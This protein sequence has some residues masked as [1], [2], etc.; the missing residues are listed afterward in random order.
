MSSNHP[1]DRAATDRSP[2]VDRWGPRVQALL[3]Y[4]RAL[5]TAGAPARWW[6]WPDWGGSTWRRLVVVVL[7]G[8]LMSSLFVA[9]LAA[10][11]TAADAPARIQSPAGGE[12]VVTA[13]RASVAAGARES[14]LA[15]DSPPPI[16]PPDPGTNRTY[17]GTFRIAAAN[18]VDPARNTSTVRTLANRNGTV[19]PVNRTVGPQP[20]ALGSARSAYMMTPRDA[21]ATARQ[22]DAYYLSFTR[23]MA[24][25][26]RDRWRSLATLREWGWVQAVRIVPRQTGLAEA[27]PS[28]RAEQAAAATQHFSVTARIAGYRDHLPVHAARVASMN[29]SYRVTNPANA[30][31]NLGDYRS[32]RRR[33]INATQALLRYSELANNREAARQNALVPTRKG[34][35]VFPPRSGGPIPLVWRN[36]SRPAVRDA[37]V[38]LVGVAPGAW[39]RDGYVTP[40]D[41]T[42]FTYVPWDYRLQPPDDYRESELCRRSTVDGT[43]AGTGA[44]DAAVNETGAENENDSGSRSGA[45]TSTGAGNRS[46]ATNGR[47]SGNTTQNVQVTRFADYTVTDWNASVE[48]VSVGG[49][50]MEEIM[51][52]VWMT[53]RQSGHPPRIGPGRLPLRASVNISVTVKRH[54]GERG[55]PPGCNWERTDYTSRTMTLSTT[56]PVEAVPSNAST[57]QIDAHLYDRPAS[58]VVV[59]HFQGNQS[60]AVNPWSR[61]SV[62]VGNETAIVQ[63]PWRFYPVMRND[64]VER[65]TAGGATTRQASFSWN[66]TFPHLSRTR[67]AVAPV[68]TRMARPSTA[69]WEPRPSASVVA[70]S[71]PGTDLPSTIVAPH[72][73]NGT[74]VYARYVGRLHG[75][76][77]SQGALVSAEA[78]TVFGPADAVN[79]TVTRYQPA[80]LD[81]WTAS[82]P[83]A[84]QRRVY[85]RLTNRA[86]AP[87][88]NRTITIRGASPRTV[89]TNASG[90][91]SARVTGAFLIARFSGDPWQASRTTYY[92]ST[93]N[94]TASAV[95]L[96]RAANSVVGYLGA[97]TSQIVQIAAWVVLGVFLVWW[98]WFWGW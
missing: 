73:A 13:G 8:F 27:P 85:V 34:Q 15:A 66:G 64:A 67:V 76:T 47:Q 88:P 19:H 81:V 78:D 79:V 80:A 75:N 63:A 16:P 20:I 72:N 41:R 10:S 33:K 50:T 35:A 51:P 22:T 94:V 53:G 32:L 9:V 12:Q 92:Q 44:G 97:I 31:V 70:R 68:S 77:L 23:P 3:C 55:G 74:T 86:G 62:T 83:T 5:V 93:T 56:Q 36:G 38:G 37:Y 69:W 59:V 89:T 95:P 4:C 61:V 25:P 43:P 6:P 49:V 65:R 29:G 7:C 17:N 96:V 91:A 30:W 90:M 21:L 45:D 2:A 58:D 82:R 11:P 42:M 14:R 48:R 39:Y 98:R 18:D 40:S 1:D 84:N 28:G 52:G 26:Y 24:I 87:I 71:I 46:D 54:Y 60:L 57:L